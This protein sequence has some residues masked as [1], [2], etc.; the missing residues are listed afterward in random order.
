M[1]VAN[2]E[3]ILPAHVKGVR[4]GYRSSITYP[5]DAKGAGRK[6]GRNRHSRVYVPRPEKDDSEHGSTPPFSKVWHNNEPLIITSI[7]EV[8]KEKTSCKYCG[9]EFPHGKLCIVPFDVV[10]SH[11]ERWEYRNPNK[12]PN[13]PKFLKSPYGKY[14]VNYYCV[15]RE[16]IYKRF[17]Y[18]IPSLLE[19]SVGLKLHAGHKIVLKEQ[20][21]VQL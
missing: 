20:L 7:T 15:K 17:P 18:F 8:P 21:G 12:D 1:A 4:V 16:R 3:N 13:E 19:V 11:R 6:G 9:N 14:T 2:R 5:Q 10:I